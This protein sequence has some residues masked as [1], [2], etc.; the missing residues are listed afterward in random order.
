M[1]YPQRRLEKMVNSDSD[2]DREVAASADNLTESDMLGLALDNNWQI[3][4][5]LAKNNEITIATITELVYDTTT[6][7]RIAIASHHK[8]PEDLKEILLK[9]E[10]EKVRDAIKR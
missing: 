4:L 1:T 8:L 7:V 10:K 6:E 9:D 2:Y 3:R 5:A